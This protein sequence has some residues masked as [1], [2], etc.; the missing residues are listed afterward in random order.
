M[1][2][3]A[4][5]VLEQIRKRVKSQLIGEFENDL[6]VLKFTEEEERRINE[7]A[8]MDIEEGTKIKRDSNI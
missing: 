1:G 5:I 4:D 8:R 2:K 3:H 6:E 7:A